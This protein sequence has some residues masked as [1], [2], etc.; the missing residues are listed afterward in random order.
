MRKKLILAREISWLSFNARVLQEA[1][2]TTLPVKERI[3]FLGIHSNNSDEFFRVRVAV[4][5]KM[6][7][8]AEKRKKLNLGKNPQKMLDKIHRIVMKQQNEFN[9]TWN[10]LVKELEKEKVYLVD[11][12]QLNPEQEQFVRDYFD[13]D[14]SSYIVPLFIEKNPMPPVKDTHIFLGVMMQKSEEDGDQRFAIIEIP[15]KIHGRFVALPSATGTQTFIL[16]EDLIRFNLPRIFAHLG[17]TYFEAHMFKITRDAEIDIDNDVSTSF[18]QKIQKGLTNRRKA[19]PIRFLYEKEMNAHLLEFLV[20]KLNITSKDSI[21]PGG[22]IRNF[23]DFMDFPGTLKGSHHP[24]P[25]KHPAFAKSHRITDVV[26]KQDVMLNVPYH[27]FNAIVDLLR[28]AAMDAEVK[29]IKITAYR[30]AAESRVCNAL[31]N[32]ARNGKDVH[33]ML[34]LQ[35]YSDE[36]ANLNWKSRLEDEG[37]KVY[38]GI[39]NMKVHAKICVIEKMVGEKKDLYGFVGTGNLNEKTAMVYTDQF[40]L[41]SDRNIM[42][43]IEKVFIAIENPI[44]KWNLLN[45][46]KN[47][48]ISP[49]TMRKKLIGLIN[50][51]IKHVKAGKKGKIILNLNS[52]SDEKL[53]K[54]LTKAC[55]AGVELQ[56]IVRGIFCFNVDKCPS[57]YPVT[58]I[59]IVD[60]YLEHGRIFYFHNDG[61]KDIYISSADWMERNLDHR[62]EVAVPVKDVNIK[63]EL[64]DMLKIRLSDNVKARKLDGKLLNEFVSGDGKNRVRSQ[65]AIYHYLQDKRVAK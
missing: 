22:H 24:Q 21:I 40:L 20:R 52:L 47:L 33:V 46:C 10:V 15:T 8:A 63:E 28:E 2:D 19:K 35:A 27:S 44:T 5:K 30:L 6:I 7:Q 12:K 60:E 26:M 53:I 42:G 48:L 49:T 36:E 39:P 25:F 64:L 17:Y 61:K 31:I 51:E 50:R 59:S 58:A 56:M 3:R 29:S 54:K 38:L 45:Q 34:E 62:V 13:Q 41:T 23:R 32:A 55:E 65:E 16:V 43:D 14:V 11:D 4:L 57:K 37:V 18:I 1:N 9:R